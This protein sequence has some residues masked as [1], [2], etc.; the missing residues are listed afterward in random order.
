MSEENTKY[1]MFAIVERKGQRAKWIRLGAAFKNKD[2][3]FTGFC[4]VIP[5]DAF[6]SGEMKINIREEGREARE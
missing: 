2:D 5:I 3:S 1:T 6:V 4:D